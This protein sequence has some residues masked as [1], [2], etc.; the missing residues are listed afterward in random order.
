[1]LSL[2]MLSGFLYV[3]RP[4]WVGIIFVIWT[5]VCGLV[6]YLGFINNFEA[7]PPRIFLLFIPTIALVVWISLYVSRDCLTSIPY[8]ILIGAQSFRIIVELLI[9]QAV[10][11]GVA[12]PQLTW[13]GMN[14]DIVTG[15]VALILAPFA[16]N[17][18]RWILYLFNVVGLWLLL[19]VV[20]V[21]ILSFP[22]PFQVLEPRN[23]WVVHFPFIW[24]P[25]VLVSF[26]LM[27]HL[28]LFAKLARESRVLGGSESSAA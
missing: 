15:V 26:A 16:N 17:A 25:I 23:V 1:M 6:T 8:G 7:L 12:P 20:T 11:E 3:V 4:K 18:P 21:A 24:L 13:S 5:F 19:Q 28:V 22:T 14:Y 9:H 10:I 27:G 2:A